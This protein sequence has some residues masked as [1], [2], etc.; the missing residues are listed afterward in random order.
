MGRPLTLRQRA[1]HG[2]A[3]GTFVPWDILVVRSLRFRAELV[4]RLKGQIRR[5]AGSLSQPHHA[6]HGRPESSCSP[7]GFD[8]SCLAVLGL[9]QIVMGVPW[10]I[11]HRR[12]TQRSLVGL[13]NTDTCR[14]YR[15]QALT[16]H[17]SSMRY[18]WATHWSSGD[19]V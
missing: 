13:W 11:G 17:G 9:S 12:S 14:T 6:I 1:I 18:P 4:G 15:G 10:V 3:G 19:A 5:P 8:E 2:V 16:A 7:Y